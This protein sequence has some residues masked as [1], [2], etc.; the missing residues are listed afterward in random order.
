MLIFKNELIT[1]VGGGVGVGV[2]WALTWDVVEKL[3]A[4]PCNGQTSAARPPMSVSRELHSL[5][6]EEGLQLKELTNEGAV[7]SRSHDQTF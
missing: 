2:G 3:L 7:L 4:H 1:G 6:S 5:E